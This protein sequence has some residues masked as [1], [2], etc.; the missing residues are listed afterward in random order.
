LETPLKFDFLNMARAASLET[1]A[2]DQARAL[3]RFCDRIIG[4]HVT[5]DVPHRHQQHGRQFEANIRLTVPGAVLVAS[6]TQR[7]TGNE[8]EDARVAVRH[9]FSEIRRQL[10]DYVRVRRGEV[11]THSAPNAA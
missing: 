2:K 7:D 6:C 11:K 5:L 4:C 10:Q 3:E 1:L 9:A 8:Q